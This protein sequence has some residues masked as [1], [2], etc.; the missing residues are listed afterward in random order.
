M[1]DRLGAVV[2][3]HRKAWRGNVVAAVVLAATAIALWVMARG[4]HD[5]LTLAA[6]SFGAAVLL[7]ASGLHARRTRAVV[8]QLGFAWHRESLCDEVLWSE[9]R[10]VE[11]KPNPTYPVWIAVETTSDRNLVIPQ[12]VEDFEALCAALVRRTPT[13]ADLPVARVISS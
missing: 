2:S 10:A 13:V 1:S 8:H 3:V 5:V 4:A 7:V 9:I 12:H 6:V 11:G